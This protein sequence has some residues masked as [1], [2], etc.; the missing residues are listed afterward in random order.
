MSFYGQ[1]PEQLQSE[2]DK[3]TIKQLQNR[4]IELQE[5][6]TFGPTY[7]S[8]RAFTG[9]LGKIAITNEQKELMQKVMWLQSDKNEILIDI[10]KLEQRFDK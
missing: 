1:A 4:I 3:E 10:D 7:E 9:H 5:K 8:M 2:K 6:V